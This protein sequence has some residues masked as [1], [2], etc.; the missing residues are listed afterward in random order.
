LSFDNADT[1]TYHQNKRK[2]AQ[3]DLLKLQTKKKVD[4]L[5]PNVACDH[6]DDGV[7]V[8]QSLG[9]TW[10]YLQKYKNL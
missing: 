1:L 10:N 2:Q 3:N 9:S 7:I 6:G 4:K 8:G 5:L